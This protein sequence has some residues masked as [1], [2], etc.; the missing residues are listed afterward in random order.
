VALTLSDKETIP[1]NEFEQQNN[2][3]RSEQFTGWLAGA[4]TPLQ[5]GRRS[6]DDALGVG[7]V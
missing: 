5:K 7:V 6:G 3:S 2:R 4:C 1:D